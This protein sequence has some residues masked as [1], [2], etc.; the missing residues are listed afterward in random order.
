MNA[1]LKGNMKACQ[2]IIESGKGD[3][4]VN[5][6]AGNCLVLASESGNIQ[7]VKYLRGLEGCPNVNKGDQAGCTAL[8]V[9]TYNHRVDMVN[10]W[11][12]DTECEIT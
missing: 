3:Y 10:Y 4:R 5:S 11:L 6:E 1:C 7:L 12:E 8:Y 9:A 2:I